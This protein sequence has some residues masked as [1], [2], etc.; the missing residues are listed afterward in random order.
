M[1]T[2]IS[3]LLI[4]GFTAKLFGQFN[5]NLFEIVE[6]KPETCNLSN[7]SIE[8]KTIAGVDI[9]W[10]NG[11]TESRIDNLP[12]GEYTVIVT[13][14]YDCTERQ[15]IQ[16]REYNFNFEFSSESTY[17]KSSRCAKKLTVIVTDDLGII[18]DSYLFNFHW[19]YIVNGS[20]SESKSNYI[21][22]DASIE[23]EVIVEVRLKDNAIDNVVPC[24]IYYDKRCYH[25]C[26]ES[27]CTS[28]PKDKKLPR[29]FVYKTNF[30]SKTYK[31][32]TP[33]VIELLVYGDG[34]CGFTDLR[35]YIL[36]DNDGI[37]IEGLNSNVSLSDLGISPGYVRFTNNDGWARVPNGS[38][39]TI[40]QGNHKLSSN[41]I[42][43]NDP[44]DTNKDFNYVVALNDA[45]YFEGNQAILQNNNSTTPGL[46]QLI[47]PK[48][49][50]S[51]IQIRNPKNIY[52][53]GVSFGSSNMTKDSSSFPLHLTNQVF[54]RKQV[55]MDSFSID[56]PAHF[57]LHDCIYPFAPDEIPVGPMKTKI[58]ELRSCIGTRSSEIITASNNTKEVKIYP[59]PFIDY[60][61]IE[62][63]KG[64]EGETLVEVFGVDGKKI[65]EEKLHI[66]NVFNTKRVN[67]RRVMAN[68]VYFVKITLSDKSH[69]FHKVVKTNH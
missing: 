20:A 62:F 55:R 44:E 68:S 23:T 11:S 9:E 27:S 17:S 34:N 51:A 67:F 19:K 12:A 42:T 64:K 25:A 46:W 60:I 8:I 28:P 57:S 30:S 6:I 24:G 52:I 38:I 2:F 49:P 26:A 65:F 48:S 50:L 37:L 56:N 14:R 40:Y 32:K 10:S 58:M 16:V 7:G 22:V 33:S 69:E 39:I 45:N 36:D 29:V 66:T 4:I 63:P 35:G 31:Y 47:E 15:T 5:S 3:F 18:Y 21:I 1:K 61:D 59:N 41:L 54:D 53:H 13:D 43:L